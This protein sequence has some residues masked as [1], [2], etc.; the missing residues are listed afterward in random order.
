MNLLDKLFAAIESMRYEGVWKIY[1]KL[2]HNIPEARYQYYRETMIMYI[3]EMRAKHG[4]G[5]HFD[6]N[7]LKD[8]TQKIA[9]T[10]VGMRS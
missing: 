2:L 9:A 3:E 4:Y 7:N 8:I 1:C 5:W 10:V 6:E